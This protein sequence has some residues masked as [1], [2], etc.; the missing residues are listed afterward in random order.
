[1]ELNDTKMALIANAL[2]L[3]AQ[4]DR[5]AAHA[6]KTPKGAGRAAFAAAALKRTLLD[7]A[8]TCDDLANAFACAHSVE[9]DR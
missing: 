2:W 3:K 7:Q 9:I 5:E 1:M 4:G 6:I 8:D